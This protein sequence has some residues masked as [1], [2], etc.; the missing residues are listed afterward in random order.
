MAGLS[1]FRSHLTSHGTTTK[2]CDND[3]I[4]DICWF[5]DLDSIEGL[6]Y[7][8]DEDESDTRDKAVRLR[9]ILVRDGADEE[10]DMM[11]EVMPQEI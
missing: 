5:R 4:I 8:T 11:A 2:G 6:R 10:D 1:G 9:T 3:D 7:D